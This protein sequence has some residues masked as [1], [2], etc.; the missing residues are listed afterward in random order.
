MAIPFV[1]PIVPAY[2]V[3]A[4]VP[5]SPAT[6]SKLKAEGNPPKQEGGMAESRGR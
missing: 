3:V 4:F 5:H 2:G 6:A 1:D